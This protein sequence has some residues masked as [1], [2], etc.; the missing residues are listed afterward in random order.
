MLENAGELEECLERMSF[1]PSNIE[2]RYEPPFK[3]TGKIDKLT[4]KLETEPK[5]AAKP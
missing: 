4:F 1:N 2:Y 5:A 3:F